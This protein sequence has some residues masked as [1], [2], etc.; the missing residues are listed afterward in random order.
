M[1]DICRRESSLWSA[2]CSACGKAISYHCWS[3]TARDGGRVYIVCSAC[4]PL[5]CSH[6][7]CQKRVSPDA[8]MV[9][10]TQCAGCKRPFCA[11]HKCEACA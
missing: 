5:E 10:V 9:T 2:R 8:P 1:C 6:Y 3:Y 7:E 11:K 4:M